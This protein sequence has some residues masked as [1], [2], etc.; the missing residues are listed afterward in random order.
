MTLGAEQLGEGDGAWIR[1]GQSRLGPGRA[2]GRAP[3]DRCDAA[4]ELSF[5]GAEPAL[6][7]LPREWMYEARLPRTKVESPH[8]GARFGGRVRAGE[9]TIEVDGWP[10]MVGHN[11]GAQHAERWIWLNGLGFDSHPDAWLDMAIGRV[12]LGPLT[13]PWVANGCLSL[14]GVRHRVGGLRPLRASAVREA[15]E[16]CEF[17]LT[18]CDVSVHGSVGSARKHVVGWVYADPDGSEHHTAN[19]SIAT[20]T[21]RVERRGAA[22]L[23]LRTEGGGVYEVGMRERDY[24]VPIQPF[25]DGQHPVDVTR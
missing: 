13:T 14:D 10:G 19:G 20:M 15:P 22:P 11:W 21:L 17:S 7:H 16:R 25:P 5:E 24:G 4:W 8:P 3:A 1:I 9:R 6:R 18:G 2:V 12:R 23:E